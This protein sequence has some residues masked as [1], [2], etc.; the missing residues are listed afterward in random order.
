MCICIMYS[1]LR[2]KF[3]GKFNGGV[4]HVCFAADQT[5]DLL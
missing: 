3:N 5:K 2:E 1:T 4:D